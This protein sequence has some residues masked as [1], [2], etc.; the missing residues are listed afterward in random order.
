MKPKACR[1]FDER[2]LSVMSVHD[3]ISLAVK[4]G[5]CKDRRSE[6]RRNAPAL[7][8]TKVRARSAAGRGVRWTVLMVNFAP[9]IYSRPKLS[10]PTL[11]SPTPPPT[12]D[13]ATRRDATAALVASAAP[14]IIR[15]Y[16]NTITAIWRVLVL[17]SRS[18]RIAAR[19]GKRDIRDKRD[20]RDT[21]E[22]TL[23][24]KG[25]DAAIRQ[26]KEWQWQMRVLR[27]P[28]KEQSL[29]SER[30]DPPGPGSPSRRTAS[31]RRL[32]QSS[33]PG[34]AATWTSR[35]YHRRDSTS[36]TSVLL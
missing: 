35:C 19:K 25:E 2:S 7:P 26:A 31:P 30:S 36:C 15:P 5:A 4:R 27:S 16:L 22:T 6:G 12:A 14:G 21:G 17:P 34:R 28:L 20:K 9:S 29:G 3:E 32:L 24:L 33:F 1:P 18:R 8:G 11:S 13:R 10:S 23:D